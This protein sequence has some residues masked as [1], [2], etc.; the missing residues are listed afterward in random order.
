MGAPATEPKALCGREEFPPDFILGIALQALQH[1]GKRARV[2]LMQ[3]GDGGLPAHGSMALRIGAVVDMGRPIAAQGVKQ[4]RVILPVE[5][6]HV[7]PKR[8]LQLALGLWGCHRRMSNRIVRFVQKAARSL[9]VKG[10][11][12]SNTTALGITRY[13]RIA[14]MSTRMMVRI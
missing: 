2:L 11:P 14:A 5:V 13:W 9:P 7:V 3:S 1:S 10:V 4:P 8:P 12:L 6:P